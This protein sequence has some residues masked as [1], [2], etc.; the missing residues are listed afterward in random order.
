MKRPID[1]PVNFTVPSHNNSVIHRRNEEDR[2]QP[3]P[4]IAQQKPKEPV[5]PDWTRMSSHYATF[6]EFQN[7]RPLTVWRVEEA[8]YQLL[9]RGYAQN[10]RLPLN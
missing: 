3:I 4:S 6:Q 2:T 8:M 10:L 7:D 5:F 9:G 1:L